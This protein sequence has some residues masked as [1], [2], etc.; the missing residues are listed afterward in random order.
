M[1]KEK[2]EEQK[3]IG[4]IYERTRIVKLRIS[5]QHPIF[6]FVHFTP[7]TSNN[8]SKFQTYYLD[9]FILTINF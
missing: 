3:K 9:K 2:Y 5:I 7:L 1:I 4:N 8:E 6:S